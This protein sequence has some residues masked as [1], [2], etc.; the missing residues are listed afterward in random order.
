MPV[1][2]LLIPFIAGISYEILKVSDR[3]QK[4][5]IFKIISMPGMLL[6]KI[7]TQEPDSKQAEVAIFA[8]KKLLQAEKRG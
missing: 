1:R 4:N 3:H 6:Q 5:P 8:V 2:I 7:T